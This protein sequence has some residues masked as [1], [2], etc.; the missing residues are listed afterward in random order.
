MTTSENITKDEARLTSII[1]PN[2]W[3]SNNIDMKRES[4]P[5]SSIARNDMWGSHKHYAATLHS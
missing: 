2:V 4:H 3:A 1:S 5:H